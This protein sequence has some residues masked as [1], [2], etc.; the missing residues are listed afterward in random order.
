[1]ALRSVGVLAAFQAA[2]VVVLWSSWPFPH[3]LLEYNGHRLSALA[4]ILSAQLIVLL[5]T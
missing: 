3:R 2:A 5:L 4:V 1:V